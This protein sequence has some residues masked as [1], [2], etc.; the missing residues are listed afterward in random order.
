LSISEGGWQ[1]GPVAPQP[2][3]RQPGGTEGAPA[4]GIGH[5]PGD[6][7]S[8]RPSRDVGPW[9]GTAGLWGAGGRPCCSIAGAG[10]EAPGGLTWGCGPWAGWGE[11]GAGWAGTVRAGGALINIL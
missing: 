10:P 7:D 8:P 4:P 1:P 11:A 2:G 9:L 5:L 6:G 3:A